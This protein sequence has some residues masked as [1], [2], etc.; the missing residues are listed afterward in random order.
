MNAAKLSFSY[1]TKYMERFPNSFDV[2]KA[3]IKVQIENLTLVEKFTSLSKL[4]NIPG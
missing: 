4:I 3:F 1:A 2:E